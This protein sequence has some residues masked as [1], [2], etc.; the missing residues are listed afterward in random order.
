[1]KIIS[2]SA[3]TEHSY[4]L[5]DK[6]GKEIYYKEWTNEKGKIIESTA[7]DCYGNTI[8]D[9]DLISQIEAAVDLYLVMCS[10]EGRAKKR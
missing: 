6:D 4:I 3:A 10:R 1:M 8:Y 2:K 7:H 9:D 5:E